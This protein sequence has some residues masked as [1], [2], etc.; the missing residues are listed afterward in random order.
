MK[1]ITRHDLPNTKF[2][3]LQQWEKMKSSMNFFNLGYGEF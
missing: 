1:K 3:Q 2:L